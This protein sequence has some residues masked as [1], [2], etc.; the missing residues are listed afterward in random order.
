[1]WFWA[2]LALAGD[3]KFSFDDSLG[4]GERPKFSVTSPV[5]VQELQVVVEAGAEADEVLKIPDVIVRS[6]TSRTLA[7]AVSVA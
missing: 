3:L 7:N 6:V 1:M 4:P 5:P 2:T